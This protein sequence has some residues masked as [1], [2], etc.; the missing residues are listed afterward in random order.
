MSTIN[1][2][3]FIPFETG[4]P[5]ELKY[6]N[7]Q[8][9]CLAFYTN[10]GSLRR[11]VNMDKDI[12]QLQALSNFN[13]K[14]LDYITAPTYLQVI[15]WFEEKYKIFIEFRRDSVNKLYMFIVKNESSKYPFEIANYNLTFE[16]K[17]DC[18]QAAIIEALK[19]IQ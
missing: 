14:I 2:K 10:T 3:D 15:N 1:T 11:Y 17:I 13:M 9:P 12:H 4:I 19:L 16:N 18:I 8:E 7:F 5:M 6:R